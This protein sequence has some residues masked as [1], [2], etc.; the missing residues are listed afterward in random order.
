M[1]QLA[2]SQHK[3]DLAAKAMEL[4]TVHQQQQVLRLLLGLSLK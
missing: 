2:E 4:L 3:D 1:A